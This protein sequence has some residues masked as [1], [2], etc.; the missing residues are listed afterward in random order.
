MTEQLDLLGQAIVD[1]ATTLFARLAELPEDQRIDTI[2]ALRTALARHSPMRDEPVDCVLWVKADRLQANDYN[3]NVVAPPEMRLLK[4]SID[5]D[6]Y[7]QPIVAWPVE[8]W[9]PTDGTYEVVDGF[10]RHRVGKETP[11]LRKRLHGRLPVTV[12][13]PERTERTDRMAATVRH[14]RARGEHTVDGMSDMVLELARR[15]KSDEWIGQELGMQPDEVLRLRQ[16]QGLAEL[17]ADREFS[18]AFEADTEP[19]WPTT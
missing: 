17:F 16:V 8:D 9:G 15:G 10:H 7:T 12:I 6:G 11:A 3:P 13:R 18:E 19:Q 4:H 5:A 14:N 1:D 2:N